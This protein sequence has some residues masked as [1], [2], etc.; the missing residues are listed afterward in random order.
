MILEQVNRKIDLL[1]I[2]NRKYQMT[3]GQDLVL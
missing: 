1:G 3:I 2:P